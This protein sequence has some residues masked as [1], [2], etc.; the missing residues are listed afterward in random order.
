MPL[1]P[2]IQSYTETIT[3]GFKNNGKNS[4][5]TQKRGQD[6]ICVQGHYEDDKIFCKLP[7][8]PSFNN[9]DP[10]YLVDVSLNGQEFTN[11]PQTIR[12]YLISDVSMTPN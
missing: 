11:H 9:E 8:I 5:E 6:W 3:V 4:T 7:N 10:F 1:H 12:F 2:L